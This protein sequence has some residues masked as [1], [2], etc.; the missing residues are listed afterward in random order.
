MHVVR[1]NVGCVQYFFVSFLALSFL[2]IVTRQCVKSDALTLEG[3]S[4]HQVCIIKICVLLKNV[5]AAYD[6]SKL[7]LNQA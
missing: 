3:V 2:R 6:G 4:S 1:R 5:Y 7:Y